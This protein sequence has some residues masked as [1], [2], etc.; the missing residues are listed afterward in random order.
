MTGRAYL[1]PGSRMSG[2][3]DPPRRCIVLTQFGPVLMAARYPAGTEILEV[4]WWRGPPLR[5]LPRSETSYRVSQP[6]T[7]SQRSVIYLF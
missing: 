6:G 2:R 1:D 7:G 4:Q 3:Y 5:T